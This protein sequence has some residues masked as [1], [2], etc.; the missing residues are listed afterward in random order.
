M[1]PYPSEDPADYRTVDLPDSRKSTIRTGRPP[2]PARPD[3]CADHGRELGL[4]LEEESSG[5]GSDGNLIG[6]LG[7]PVLDGLGAQGAGAHSPDEHVELE[8]IPVRAKL[9]SHFV[10]RS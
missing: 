6:A 3:P 9:L 2:G 10:A 4:D 5:G 1:C 7:V 8:S